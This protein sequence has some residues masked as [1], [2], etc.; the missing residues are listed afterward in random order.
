MSVEPHNFVRK[1][2]AMRHLILMIDNEFEIPGPLR[3]KLTPIGF[4]VVWVNVLAILTDQWLKRAEFGGIIMNL[5][6]RDHCG[7]AVLERLQE[8]HIDIP[9]I[10]ISSGSNSEEL[11]EAIR[12]GARDYLLKP[13]NTQLLL[14]KCLRYF[15]P[16]SA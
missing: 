7:I 16:A 6:M 2:P 1:Q 11:E 13:I 3:E 4:D 8:Q 15:G 9:V 12:R 10:V 5:D 14:E